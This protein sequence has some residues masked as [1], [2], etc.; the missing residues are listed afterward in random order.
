MAEWKDNTGKVFNTGS[1]TTPTAG[2][3][4]T[5]WENG[6]LKHGVY[7]NGV[8]NTYPDPKQ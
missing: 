6:V 8:F 5:T 3:Q 4:G 1:S 2:S 7:S